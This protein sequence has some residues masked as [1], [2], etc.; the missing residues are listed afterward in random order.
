MST[1]MIECIH[2][3]MRPDQD[4]SKVM[5]VFDTDGPEGLFEFLGLLE[6]LRCSLAAE[7]GVEREYLPEEGTFFRINERS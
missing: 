7:I 2:V 5:T 6:E 1:L 4:P 3:P